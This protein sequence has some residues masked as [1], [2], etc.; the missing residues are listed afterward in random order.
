MKKAL[1]IVG[2][3]V[4]LAGLILFGIPAFIYGVPRIISPSTASDCTKYERQDV[5][6][7]IR[8]DFYHRLPTWTEDTK[9]LQSDTPELLFETPTNSGGVMFVPFKAKTNIRTI[10]YFASFDCKYDRIEYS[11][12]KSE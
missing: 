8:S 10:Q 6:E 9:A 7:T 5:I 1:I 3:L 11:V 12:D 4:A 2:I